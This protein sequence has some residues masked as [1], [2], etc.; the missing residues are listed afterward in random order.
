MKNKRYLSYALRRNLPINRT[1]L[2]PLVLGAG[3]FAG[4]LTSAQ[5]ANITMSG[6]D[7]SGSSSYNAGTNWTGGAAPTAGNAY[8]VNGKLIR[9]PL[10][11]SAS[12]N[13]SY[14]FGG[15]SL[16]IQTGGDFLIKF[17][18]TGNNL[19]QTL[20]TNNLILSGGQV[21]YGPNGLVGS[22]PSVKLTGNVTLTSSTTSSIFAGGGLTM[23]VAAP[24]SGSGNLTIGASGSAGKIVFSGNNTYTGTT[25]INFGTLQL[26]K[27]ASLDASNWTAAQ[28]F[29]AS[30]ATLALN[31]GG[32]NEFTTG[33]V[34]TLLTNL[35]GANGT[36]T[37][38][39]AAGSIIGFDTTNA[40]VGT[41]TVADNITNSTGT[42]G[43]TINLTKLGTNTLILTG[44]NTYTGATTISAGTLQIGA[45]T[46]AGT[47]STS[48]GITNN[49]A[50]VY[51]VGA[52]NR[53]YANVI[54]GTGSLTQ[55][56]TGTLTLTA[57]NSFSGGLKIN[58]GTVFIN[59][60]FLVNS[61]GTGTVT[62]GDAANTGAAATLMFSC[63]NTGPPTFTNALSSTGNGTNII[64]VIGFNPNFTGGLTL[65]NNLTIATNNSAGSFLTFN[66]GVTGTG[67]ITV[68]INNS[69]N[70]SYVN[71][72]SAPVNN[73]GTLTYNNAAV[74]MGGTAG[75][76]GTGT[77]TNTITGGVGSNVTGI[78]QASNSN[79]L[80]IST[81]ALTVNSTATTLNASG[82]AQFTVSGGVTGTGNL[83]LNSN[84]NTNGILLSTTGV[85]VTGT[86]TNS[87]TGTSSTTISA[88]IG[89]SVTGVT[90]N[91]AT[92]G[93]ILT[94]DNTYSGATTI[95]AG[96]LQVGNGG[97][98]GSIASTTGV[99]NSGALIYK[100]S[101]AL[102]VGYVI[103]G[104]GSFTQ[105]GAG[106]TTL[107][108]TNT[109]SGATN[110][111]AGKLIVNGSISTST[112]T[113][114]AVGAT[115]G[116]TGTVGKAIVNGTL[117]PGLSPGQ[118]N[119]ANTLGLNGTT[120]MEID[121]TSGAGVTGGHDFVNLTGAGAAGVLT[122]GGT[123]TLDMG[124]VF[125]TGTYSWNLFDMASTTGTL[126]TITLADQY[127][128]SLLD[129]D[130][131]GIWDLTSGSNTW[132][133]T[134]STGVLGLTV[135]P[136]PRAALLGS[137]GMLAL[138]RRRRNC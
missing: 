84:N 56:G 103:G 86:L 76:A 75:V 71:F 34:T 9:G 121:G 61:L 50:L 4:L 29:V 21:R 62:I 91:S 127:S 1:Q 93:L 125:G 112:L 68:S 74:T 63:T 17:T 25:K 13:T 92:S 119:F 28:T 132:Q 87:G 15:D 18:P 3:L 46:D 20:Q 44:N 38:G 109:Y 67:N 42:G 98:S 104:N 100:R 78:T 35:G 22:N 113:T 89:S 95:S 30:G 40:S 72:A 131:N 80:T 116:G 97:T 47:I 126:A 57:G 118:M 123:L 32:T 111:N 43:G 8:I 83:I 66:G 24:I 133:F 107:T 136:E 49:G 122:Y 135:I 10:D 6:N 77:G 5:A 53:T 114:V 41:F 37:T 106:T 2:G 60:G 59:A 11:G 70:G 31:V 96:I 88:V 27:V 117:A 45:G 69:N 105:A 120:I 79:P 115:L 81:N 94:A 54:S 134:E 48:S 85:N 102:S 73:V 26:A 82:T 14:T 58:A 23:E 138:L 52:G 7:A 55:A 65:A 129:G 19:T 128:G 39:F 36:T 137:L 33:N 124:V 99:T 110:V 101:D 16:D 64:G 108:G 51:N 90:Q 130:S 12:A